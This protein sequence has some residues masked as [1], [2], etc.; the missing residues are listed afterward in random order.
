MFKLKIYCIMFLL[1]LCFSCSK[2]EKNNLKLDS[3]KSDSLQS[4]VTE[5]SLK[6]EYARTLINEYEKLISSNESIRIN[7]SIVFE[8]TILSDMIRCFHKALL[9]NEIKYNHKKLLPVLE[10]KIKVKDR[11]KKPSEES[12]TLDEIYN[13]TPKEIFVRRANCSSN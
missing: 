10:A 9:R 13:M 8:D 5:E 12:I 7:D 4:Q 11:I 3:I 1:C 2:N 6:Y